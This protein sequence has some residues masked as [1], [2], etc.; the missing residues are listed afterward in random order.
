MSIEALRVFLVEGAGLS[1]F[2]VGFKILSE[3]LKRLTARG[4]HKLLDPITNNEISSSI[5]GVFAGLFMASAGSVLFIIAGFVQGQFLRVKNSYS[6]II[7]SN[8][9]GAL[10]ISLSVLPIDLLVFSMLFLTGML[11]AFEFPKKFVNALGAA[12]GLALLLFGLYEIGTVTVFLKDL[13]WV[14]KTLAF[15]LSYILVGIPIGFFLCF[16][17]QSITAVLLIALTLAANGVLSFPQIMTIFLGAQFGLAL[18]CYLPAIGFKGGAKQTVM[19]FVSYQVIGATLA[20][21]IYL[22]DHF[23]GLHLIEQSTARIFSSLSHQLLFI[24]IA[25]HLIFCIAFSFVKP[26]MIRWVEKRYS[27]TDIEVQ[28]SPKYLT[29][30]GS[31]GLDTIL[32]SVRKEQNRIVSWLPDYFYF[33]E[34]K[35]ELFDKESLDNRHLSF[36]NISER[37]VITLKDGLSSN[38]D[39]ALFELLLNIQRRHY[40]ISNLEQSTY[41]LITEYSTLKNS[42]EIELT[43]DIMQAIQTHLLTYTSYLEKHELTDLESLSLIN[44]NHDQIMQSIRSRYIL[45]SK[46]GSKTLLNL[47][48]TFEKLA[49]L[50][51]NLVLLEEKLQI[52]KKV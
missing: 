40:L 13:E 7:W 50:L 23:S 4:L 47:I 19:I 44:D 1:L 14:N 51:N 36:K 8:L 5:S 32:L 6:I 37:I 12:F 2:F 29:E 42:K 34:K 48:D 49:R 30:I 11:W 16:I 31:M 35:H 20:M 24:A 46:E 52:A 41:E 17:M 10:V 9:G 21:F 27:L 18:S 45:V 3:N 33:R 43:E 39:N 15:S 28:G 22:L 38:I 26:Y 25:Y